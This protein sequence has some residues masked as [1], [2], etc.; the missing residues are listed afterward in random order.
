MC[1]SG[2]IA[3]SWLRD[4]M[5]WNKKD[6]RKLQEYERA[7]DTEY[8]IYCW[9]GAQKLLVHCWPEPSCTMGLGNFQGEKFS[10]SLSRSR[11]IISCRRDADLSCLLDLAAHDGFEF[12]GHS[13]KLITNEFTIE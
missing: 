10:C 5:D 7:R 3:H 13:R 11:A 2:H 1:E 8:S 12:L 6:E 4:Y 9:E